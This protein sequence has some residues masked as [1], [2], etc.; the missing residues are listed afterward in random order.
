LSNPYTRRDFLQGAAAGSALLIPGAEALARSPAIA[1]SDL[2]GELRLITGGDANAVA[3][4]GAEGLLLVDGGTKSQSGTMLKEALKATGSSRLHTLFNTHWHPEQTGLNEQA[5]KNGARIIAHENTKLWLKRR[6]N[7][8]WLP[9]K[10]Y[11][12]LPATAI[13]NKSFY[14]RE[15]L[16]FGNEELVYGHLG[17]AHTDGDLYVYFKK[18]NVL[19]AG[20]VVAPEA[21][22]LLDWQTGGW[23]GGLVGAQDR[24]IKLCDDSTKIVPANGAPIDLK[25]LKAQREMFMTIFDRTVKALVKGLGPDEAY[26]TEPAKEFEAQMGDSKAFV[27]ASFKSL[28]GHYAPDA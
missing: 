27:I 7:T 18:A 10:G 12:P 26:A 14:T 25:A 21:W 20:G 1:A 4:A 19:A 6:I 8:D 24:L 5:G 3:Y 28:W 13:P 22:P 11:G 16:V 15:E 17:Q 9:A 2:G 23:I